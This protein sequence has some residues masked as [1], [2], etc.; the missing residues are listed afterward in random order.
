MSNVIFSWIKYWLEWLIHWN[1][2][3]T[4]QQYIVGDDVGMQY[5]TKFAGAFGAAVRRWTR[6]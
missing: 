1:F 2:A 6:A 3:T 5:I 4:G